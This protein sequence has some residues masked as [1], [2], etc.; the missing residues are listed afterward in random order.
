[1]AKEQRLQEANECGRGEGRSVLCK[2][3]KFASQTKWF[4]S[5]MLACKAAHQAL[6]S[7]NKKPPRKHPLTLT[8]TLPPRAG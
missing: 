2:N 5:Y 6:P 7:S 3:Q 8:L 4:E 1:M